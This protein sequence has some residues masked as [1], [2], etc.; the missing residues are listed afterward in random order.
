VGAIAPPESLAR[1][2]RLTRA[3]KSEIYREV[4][5]VEKKPKNK[6]FSGLFD[7]AVRI[8]FKT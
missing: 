8:S 3:V 4:E 1:A 6:N 7:L 2:Q 5:E